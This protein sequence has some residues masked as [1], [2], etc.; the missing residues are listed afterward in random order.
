MSLLSGGILRGRLG[1]V[2]SRGSPT[3]GRC[4]GGHV[5]G[6]N[7]PGLNFDWPSRSDLS[8]RESLT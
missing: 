4:G 3:W 1:V 8:F 7:G 6:L 5:G 2:D